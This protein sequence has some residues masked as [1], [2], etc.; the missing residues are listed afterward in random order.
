MDIR[1]TQNEADLLRAIVANRMDG[2][3]KDATDPGK[4][5]GKRRSAME[6]AMTVGELLIIL[7]ENGAEA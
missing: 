3:L 1:L 4:D 5:S 2:L 6:H 7:D